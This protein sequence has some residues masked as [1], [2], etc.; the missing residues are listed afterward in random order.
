MLLL[1]LFTA[2]VLHVTNKF[3]VKSFSK[4][5]VKYKLEGVYKNTVIIS[6]LLLD[7]GALLY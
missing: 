5:S 6:G 2:K 1:L 4:K 3:V 7:K